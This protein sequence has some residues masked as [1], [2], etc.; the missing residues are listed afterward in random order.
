[1]AQS[2]PRSCQKFASCS[3]V[4]TASDCFVERAHRRNPRPAAPGVQRDWPS[5]GSSRARRPRCRS[6]SSSRPAGTRSADPRKASRAAGSHGSS[7]RAQQTRGQARGQAVNRECRCPVHGLTPP[8]RPTARPRR[9]AGAGARRRRS[10]ARPRSRQPSAQTRRLRRCADAS[11]RQKVRRHGEILVVLARE[12]FADA[13][14]RAPPRHR[15]SPLEFRRTVPA[16]R[17]ARHDE[18]QIGQAVQVDEDF[19]LDVLGPQ[20]DHAAFGAPADGPGHVQRRSGRRTARED[21]TTERRHVLIR[22]GRSSLPAGLTSSPV[23]AVFSTRL[24]TLPPGS[25]SRAPIANRSRWIRSIIV[26]SRRH[27]RH[28]RARDRATR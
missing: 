5:A 21:E 17:D 24:A 16:I 14:R 6:A 25:A 22:A 15:D 20:A 11:R 2:R 7:A 4:Q 10:R 26:A 13:R 18:Q 27:R 19:R 9:P 12:P 1:M 8:P 28:P 3:A 23:T